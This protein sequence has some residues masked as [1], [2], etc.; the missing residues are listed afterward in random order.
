MELERASDAL[1][2]SPSEDRERN[3]GVRLQ[4]L[5]GPRSE[6]AQSGL[7]P[8]ARRDSPRRRYRAPQGSRGTVL[9]RPGGCAAVARRKHTTTI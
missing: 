6:V 1:R 7:A 2:C 9:A 4:R 3:G 8:V 5:H